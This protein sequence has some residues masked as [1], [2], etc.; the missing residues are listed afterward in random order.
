MSKN[1]HLRIHD[2]TIYGIDIFGKFLDF[3]HWYYLYF[4]GVK[5]NFWYAEYEV[6]DCIIRNSVKSVQKQRSLYF[7]PISKFITIFRRS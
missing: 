4:D 6:Q 1:F 3:R 2:D 7:E 5:T